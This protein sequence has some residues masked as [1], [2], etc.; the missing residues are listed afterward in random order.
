[1]HALRERICRR[2]ARHAVPPSRCDNSADTDWI[3][4]SQVLRVVQEPERI[5]HY[6]D[7]PISPGMTRIRL[8]EQR[9]QLNTRL[10]T[11]GHLIGHFAEPRRIPIKA[12]TWPG[13]GRVTFKP[14]GAP[15]LMPAHCKMPWPSGL[16]KTC[17]A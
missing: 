15:R 7:R 14:G 3:G 9:R 5:V 16:K 4:E 1:M 6:V 12:I 2:T 13:E 8:D 17:R 11:A 10:H